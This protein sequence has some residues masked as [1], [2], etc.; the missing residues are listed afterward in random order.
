VPDDF[1]PYQSWGGYLQTR[2][3]IEQALSELRESLAFAGYTQAFSEDSLVVDLGLVNPRSGGTNVTLYDV[4]FESPVTE[5]TPAPLAGLITVTASPNFSGVL[6]IDVTSLTFQVGGITYDMWEFVVDPVPTLPT[7]TTMT[8]EAY[9]TGA[10]LA[11]PTLFDANPIADF[12]GSLP[13][14]ATV[15]VEV[16]AGATAPSVNLSS[17][18]LTEAM[19]NPGALIVSEAQSVDFAPPGDN[20]LVYFAAFDAGSNATTVAIQYDASS[21]NGYTLLSDKSY[22]TFE[23]DVTAQ[24][25]PES[26]VFSG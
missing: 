16:A 1:D 2:E 20:E 11:D 9:V 21:T 24:L 10:D 8:I 19:V 26:L 13:R 17:L 5:A 12:T 4:V 15:A 23:G 7:A 6:S 18:F 14:I 25:V 3:P 22:Y